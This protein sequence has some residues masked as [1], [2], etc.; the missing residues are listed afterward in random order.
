M[1][2]MQDF[3]IVLCTCSNMGIAETVAKRL[4]AEF[5]AARVN[6]AP[7][8]KSVYLR[9]GEVES[10]D[11]LQLI[12]KTNESRYPA[13]EATILEVHPYELPEIVR[14]P[15]ETGISGYLS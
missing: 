6:I 2:E 15:I 8:L 11:E 3:R 10:D 4:V 7:G 5:L 13:L 12:I 1:T 14:V 9:K